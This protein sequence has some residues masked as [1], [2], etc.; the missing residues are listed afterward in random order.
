MGS[1]TLIEWCDSTVNA[2]T[3]CVGC[4]LWNG[5][6]VRRCY[7]GK[8]HEEWLA[9]SLPDLYDANFLN[10]RLAPGRIEKAARLSDLRNVERPSKPWLSGQP[11]H[12]FLGDMGD[13]LSPDV[14]DEYIKSEIIANVES[15][16]GR[17]HIWMWLVKQSGRMAE[18]SQTL[19]G[20]PENVIAM[21]TITT[22][23]TADVRLR[24][25]QQVKASRKGVSAEPLWEQ[26][27][28]P[29]YT[30]GRCYGCQTCQFSGWHQIA[31]PEVELLICGGESG[32]GARPMAVK[33]ATDLLAQCKA[34]GVPF[35]MKQGSAANW[36]KYKIFSSFPPELQVR[37]FPATV[38]TGGNDENPYH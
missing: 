13:T 14:P 25:L 15:P 21:T 38:V 7:A 4:E 16:H 8:L 3:G 12:I 37:E 11:R 28:L 34:A 35:F 17:R 1:K 33:W 26:I 6:D 20:L 19:G 24:Q 32:N 18:L 31:P 10:V 23:Q 5:A 36:P 27:E 30:L 29:R 9:K 2:V 22:Q